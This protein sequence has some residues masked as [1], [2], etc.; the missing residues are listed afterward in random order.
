M[1]RNQ[2]YSGRGSQVRQKDLKASHSFPGRVERKE[3][4]PSTETAAQ[5]P[6]NVLRSRYECCVL[7]SHNLLTIGPIP[8]SVVVPKYSATVVAGCNGA[9]VLNP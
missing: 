8:Y 3:T 9:M 6:F 4:P 2:A 1:C 5:F 7:G